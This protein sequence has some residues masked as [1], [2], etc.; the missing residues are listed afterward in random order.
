MY[1]LQVLKETQLGHQKLAFK[2]KDLRTKYKVLKASA[3]SARVKK[4]QKSLSGDDKVIALA[5]GCFAFAYEPWVDGLAL[6]G[7][8]RKHPSGVD[9]LNKERYSSTRAQELA[10]TA[11][12]YDSLPSHL[13]DALMSD[14]RRLSFKKTVSPL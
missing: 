1:R 10:I 2:Y 9:P 5:G 11:E 3:K 6:K 4:G 12:L 14:R 7:L 13:Q 8:N